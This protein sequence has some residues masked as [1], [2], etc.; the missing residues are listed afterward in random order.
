MIT[1]YRQKVTVKSGGRIEIRAPKLNPGE[2]AEV[3]VLVEK[4]SRKTKSRPALA[5]ELK[6]LFKSIQ[7][8]PRARKI[9]EAEIAAEIAAY[10]AKAA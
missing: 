5:R 7:S 6:S 8:L 3:I 1:A 2:T 10:R 4:P 9:T